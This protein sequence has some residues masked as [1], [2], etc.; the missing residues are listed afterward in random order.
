[1]SFHL[2]LCLLS[3]TSLWQA[4]YVCPF[5]VSRVLVVVHVVD[6]IADVAASDTPVLVVTSS[7]TVGEAVCKTRKIDG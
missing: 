6:I 2:P 1:M 3:R 7:V 4:T 5:R